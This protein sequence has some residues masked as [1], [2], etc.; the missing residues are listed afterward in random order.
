MTVIAWDGK[1]LAADKRAVC[2]G[3][4]TT[5]TKIFR[6]GES[7]IGCSGDIGPS[8]ALLAWFR[9]GHDPEKYPVK[10][11]ESARLLVIHRDGT[12][13]RYESA[14]PFTVED[15]MFA[16]GSGRD[17]A[18]AALRLG[19]SAREAVALTCTL[20]SECGNGIDTLTFRKRQ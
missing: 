14:H 8:L 16:A 5:V 12:I 18:L 19:R 10:D 1:T 6:V 9:D 17:F 15:T 7:L 2:A 3:A 11:T 13:L 20:S 4:C